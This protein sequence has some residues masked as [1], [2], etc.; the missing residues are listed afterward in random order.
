M[1]S[2]F[3]PAEGAPNP[4]AAAPMVAGRLA[5]PSP[6]LVV[7]Q[8]EGSYSSGSY[9]AAS[10]STNPYAAPQAPLATVDPQRDYL[11]SVAAGQKRVIFALATQLLSSIV[12]VSVAPQLPLVAGIIAIVVGLTVAYLAISLSIKV[13]GPVQGT[14]LGILTLVPWFGLFFLLI[15][16]VRATGILNL[17]GIKVG[18][19][20]ADTTGL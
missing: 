9:P 17:H 16:N 7:G 3:H 19:F 11:R 14:L 13:Y 15:I 12:L 2:E 6:G 20:G 8:P 5:T 10:P 18:F 1:G 4:A